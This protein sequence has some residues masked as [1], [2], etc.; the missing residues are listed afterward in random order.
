MNATNPFQVPSC[1]QID[2]ER[3]RRERFKRMFIAVVAM[4]ILLMI[5]LLIEG[6]MSQHARAA[7]PTS[8]AADTPKSPSN[9]PTAAAELNVLDRPADRCTATTPSP[10]LSARA[11]S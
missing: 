3:R 11:C 4:G 2:H 7:S 9:L 5:G 1:F 8:T 10:P 6:C